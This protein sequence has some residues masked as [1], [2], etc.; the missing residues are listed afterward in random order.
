MVAELEGD[1]KTQLAA[2]NPARRQIIIKASIQGG[3]IRKLPFD[4]P[5]SLAQLQAE[6]TMKLELQ[7]AP[8]S[9]KFEYRDEV[10][11]IVSIMTDSEFQLACEPGCTDHRITFFTQLED[12]PPQPQQQLHQLS[13]PENA[14]NHVHLFE[15]CMTHTNRSQQHRVMNMTFYSPKAAVSSSSNASIHKDVLDKM[16]P[17]SLQLQDFEEEC[18]PQHHDQRPEKEDIRHAEELAAR[19][20][21]EEQDRRKELMEDDARLARQ[22]Q[23]EFDAANRPAPAR[24]VSEE[25]Q[26]VRP[27]GNDAQVHPPSPSA[28]PPRI[29]DS[30][31]HNDIQ[32]AAA[33]FEL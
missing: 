22:L 3:V 6:I 26:L 29:I 2:H 31:S 15:P 5:V 9:A 17:S 32:T 8:A 12:R 28:S 24:S 21:Q 13:P 19:S 20:Q 30:Q 11:D 27:T 23:R 16:P 10:N 33:M 18:R 7:E 1:E 14:C 4:L 25:K